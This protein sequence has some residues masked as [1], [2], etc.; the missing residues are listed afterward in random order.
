[1]GWGAQC[2]DPCFPLRPHTS[3]VS[4]AD[5]SGDKA[6][7]WRQHL[8]RQIPPGA[9]SPPPVT[10]PGSNRSE[11]RATRGATPSRVV[12]AGQTVGGGG[13]R[14]LGQR[15]VRLEPQRE[16]TRLLL[17]AVTPSGAQRKEPRM[18]SRWTRAQEPEQ[19]ADHTDQFLT[20]FRYG[21]EPSL[22]KWKMSKNVKS[23][24]GACREDAARGRCPPHA[25]LSG[26]PSRA[27]APTGARARPGGRSA[28]SGP[29]GHR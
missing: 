21:E 18:E 16:G 12:P 19:A 3:Q 20:N 4:G 26:R 2:A 7:V 17:Q 25:R 15:P 1:M 28:P 13:W 9:L 8:P 27:R 24:Q 23:W 22:G 11:R 5:R 14:C 29:C 10:L 6:H